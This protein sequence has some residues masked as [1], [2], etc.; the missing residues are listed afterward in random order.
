MTSAP[1][2]PC[3]VRGAGARGQAT[4]EFAFVLPFLILGL[5]AIVQTGLVVRDQ[6][7]VVHAAREAA[8][9]ASVDPDPSRAVRAARRTLPGADVHVGTRPA[10]GGEI[11]VDVSYTSITDLPLVGVR[12]RDPELHA[13]AP[14]RV[15]K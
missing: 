10:V 5:M 11:T 15:E 12:C 4:V 6:L 2:V 13:S 14:M 3:R 9:A 7:G 1:S 8:R